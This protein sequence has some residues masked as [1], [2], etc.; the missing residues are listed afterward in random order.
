MHL[1]RRQSAL[2]EGDRVH[3]ESRQSA[4]E[5]EIECADEWDRVR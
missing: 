1:K 4:L 3:L 2:G 5:E